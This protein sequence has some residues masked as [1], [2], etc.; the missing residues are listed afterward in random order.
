MADKVKIEFAHPHG[1]HDIGDEA[2]VDAR[3]AKHLIRAGVAVP[4]TVGEAKKADVPAETAATK[5]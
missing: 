5:R 2:T 3:E 4:V 1:D